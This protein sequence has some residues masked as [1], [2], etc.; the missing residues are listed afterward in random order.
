MKKRKGPLCLLVTAPLTHDCLWHLG[1]WEPL[2]D[3]FSAS[4]RS[5]SGHSCLAPLAN[6]Y[7]HFA[8]EQSNEYVVPVTFIPLQSVRFVIFQLCHSY[9]IQS[10]RFQYNESGCRYSVL[11]GHL[12]YFSGKCCCPWY[13]VQGFICCC[14]CQQSVKARKMCYLKGQ[15]GILYGHLRTFFKRM[16]KINIFQ[17]SWWKQIAMIPI[18]VPSTWLLNR[19]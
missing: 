7:K 16:M 6:C 3:H 10:V 1:L 13:F 2:G 17:G 5:A 19:T 4:L 15:I 12:E 14:V 18:Y 8:F 11:E 9:K